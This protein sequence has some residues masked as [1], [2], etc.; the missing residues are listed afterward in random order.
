MANSVQAVG[1]GGDLT[2][3]NA[4]RAIA[5]YPKP[6]KASIAVL[7][8]TF[9]GVSFCQLIHCLKLCSS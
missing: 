2:R 1:V 6:I 8:A 5:G 7:F 3:K 4:L 9:L